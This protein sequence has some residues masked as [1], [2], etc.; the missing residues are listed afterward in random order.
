MLEQLTYNDIVTAMA[1]SIWLGLGCSNVMGM[2]NDATPSTSFFLLKKEWK[3]EG[4][5]IRST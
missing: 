5:V 2:D 1:S 3:E 4:G